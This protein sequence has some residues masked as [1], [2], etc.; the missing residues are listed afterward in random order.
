MPPH[1]M[2]AAALDG[3]TQE[4]VPRL[5]H[6]HRPVHILLVLFSR[7]LLICGELRPCRVPYLLRV[8]LDLDLQLGLLCNLPDLNLSLGVGDLEVLAHFLDTAGSQYLL[9]DTTHGVTQ[10][11]HT[12]VSSLEV[13]EGEPGHICMDSPEL[14]QLIL[15]EE[16]NGKLNQALGNDR[17]YS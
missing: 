11:L 3:L 17:H 12:V 15:G 1:G 14:P 5:P 13:T 7:L 6:L 4:L 16:I 8:L 9:L 2:I 10:G